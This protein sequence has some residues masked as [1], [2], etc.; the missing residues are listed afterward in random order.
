MF[1]IKLEDQQDIKKL[2]KIWVSLTDL[3]VFLVSTLVLLRELSLLS[4]L[5]L[6]PSGSIIALAFIY[7]PLDWPGMVIKV[8]VNS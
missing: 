5:V 2:L 7:P 4:L 1:L 6:L 3:H 8:L